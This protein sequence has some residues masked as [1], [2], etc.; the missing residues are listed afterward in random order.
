LGILYQ[1]IWSIIPKYLKS[2]VIRSGEVCVPTN[3]ES[4]AYM[5]KAAPVYVPCLHSWNF[6]RR[7]G[8]TLRKERDDTSK[9]GITDANGEHERH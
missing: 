4:A 3:D 5:A 2:S 7:G 6:R 1:K 8:D 9:I